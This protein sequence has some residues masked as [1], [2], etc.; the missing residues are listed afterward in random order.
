MDA[1][2]EAVRKRLNLFNSLGCKLADHA[3]DNFYYETAQDDL[4]A[5]LFER[6]KTGNILSR[7]EI[8]QLRSGILHWLG[9]EYANLDGFCN[10]I[11]VHNVTPAPLTETDR[12]NRRLCFY[13][14]TM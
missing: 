9:T 13:R 5:K 2:K 1:F 11:S 12:T 14:N 6:H 7:T 8:L 10:S 4:L 3:L